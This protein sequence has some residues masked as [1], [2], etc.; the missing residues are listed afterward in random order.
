ML[1]LPRGSLSEA[2]ETGLRGVRVVWTR[3]AHC[4]FT[5]CLATRSDPSLCWERDLDNAAYEA[6]GLLA[7]LAGGR[8][9]SR[10]HD[11]QAELEVR[12][13]ILVTQGLE[14]ATHGRK[15]PL[16]PGIEHL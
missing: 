12:P 7:A 11:I 10:Q 9:E 15:L 8:F 6:T 13:K 1:V 3:S 5:T 4:M 16:W 2:Y 14:R